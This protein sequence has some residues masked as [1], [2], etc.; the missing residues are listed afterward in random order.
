M[1]MHG[2]NITIHESRALSSSTSALRLVAIGGLLMTAWVH[3]KEAA[4][5]LEEVQY[6]GIGYLLLIAAAG[7]AAGLL[8]AHDRRGWWLGGA[9][10]AATLVGY[11]LTRTTG[12]PLSKDDIGNWTESAAIAAGL[13]ELVVVAACAVALRNRSVDAA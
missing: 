10:C 11:T 13:A 5:K 1:S 7:I 12:L 4:H 9:A 3:A 2:G 8:I 6:L